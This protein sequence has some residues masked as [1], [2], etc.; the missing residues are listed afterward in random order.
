MVREKCTAKM[1]ARVES[2]LGEQEKS[3]RGV[4]SWE[5]GVNEIRL[6]ENVKD[7]AGIASI[8]AG[9]AARM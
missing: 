9:Y 6:D 3:Y 5:Q 4:G 2:Q 8:T 1:R 7:A